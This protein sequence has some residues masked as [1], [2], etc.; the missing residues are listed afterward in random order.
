MSY[1]QGNLD[2]AGLFD[3]LR[4]HLDQ[5]ARE[6]QTGGNV[7]FYLAVADRF[8][9]PVTERLGR[10]G[11]LDEALRDGQPQPWRRL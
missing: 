3:R 4:T 11:L 8:F 1:V 5:I 10:A 6:R 9:G 2:D 7:L